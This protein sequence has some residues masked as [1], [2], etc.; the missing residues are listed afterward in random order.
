MW[1]GIPCVSAMLLLASSGA[2]VHKLP[3]KIERVPFL[4]Q[5]R[6]WQALNLGRIG[7]TWRHATKRGGTSDLPGANATETNG[8]S[9]ETIINN[10]PEEEK[11]V[12]EKVSTRRRKTIPIV[13]PPPPASAFPDWAFEPR[14]FFSYELIHQSSK[15][16]ARVGRIH[17][18]HGSI[19]TYVTTHLG[20]YR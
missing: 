16:Q 15:S 19:D 12:L 20:G 18:P 2:F 11:K 7:A 3:L 5:Q 8:S 10:F 17:T 1:K 4:K 13:H 6:Q 9:S 14:S